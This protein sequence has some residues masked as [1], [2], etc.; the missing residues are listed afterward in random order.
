M[1]WKQKIKERH[2]DRAVYEEYEVDIRQYNLHT[3]KQISL[4]G[5]VCGII[6]LIVSLP[7]IH[8]LNLTRGYLAIAVLFS[9]VFAFTETIL[10]KKESL[11]LPTFYVL[12]IFALIIGILMGT[13]LGR[14]TNATTFVMMILILPFFIID[15]P[16]RLN[17]VTGVLCVIF[18]LVDS[19]V[20]TG[21]LYN[22]DIMNCIVFYCL[23]I[24]VSGQSIHAKLSDIIIKKKLKQQLD[25]D[26]LTNLRNRSA[27]ERSVEQYVHESNKNAI[28]IIMDLDNFKSVNDLMGHAY[29]D[30]VL[31]LVGEYL[32][33]AFRKSDIV[34]RLGGDEF[35]VFLPAVEE[36][37]SVTEKLTNLIKRIESIKIESQKT[38]LLSASIGVAQYPEDGCSFEILYRRADAALYHVKRD[39]KGRYAIYDANIM[40]QIPEK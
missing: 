13:Y 29:G 18:C 36:M 17:L 40:G 21:K 7:P 8:L 35:V 6:L 9:I 28:L 24:V 32:K 4:V 14:D 37:E 15:R 26:M 16:Y 12:I 34:S 39:K 22:L 30:M 5:M 25:M 1:E 2:F 38:C 23:G 10:S 27:I 3:L 31:Q 11:I 20:K 33:D 19:K